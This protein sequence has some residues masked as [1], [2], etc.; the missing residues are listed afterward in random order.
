MCPIPVYTPIIIIIIIIRKFDSQRSLNEWRRGE[1]SA[2][3]SP[4][5]V[6]AP[7][8]II[9]ARLTIQLSLTIKCTEHFCRYINLFTCQPNVQR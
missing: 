7:I 8:V 9:K 1:E 6:S 2:D 5:I 4:H 3:R